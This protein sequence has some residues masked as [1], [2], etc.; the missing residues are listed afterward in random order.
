MAFPYLE[1]DAKATRRRSEGRSANR[2]TDQ[3]S[4]RAGAPS[5]A[6]LLAGPV[7][8]PLKLGGPVRRALAAARSDCTPAV[9]GKCFERGI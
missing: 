9:I 7:R 5:A 1:E 8:G 2:V 6:L 3:R 4:S